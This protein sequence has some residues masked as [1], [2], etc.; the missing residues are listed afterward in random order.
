MDDEFGYE[1][2][3]RFRDDASRSRRAASAARC[4]DP[5]GTRASAASGAYT[6]VQQQ[7]NSP[8]VA[9]SRNNIRR[10]PGGRVGV[11]G[12]SA[13][14]DAAARADVADATAARAVASAKSAR[15]GDGGDREAGEGDPRGTVLMAFGKYANSTM[16][17]V[18]RASWRVSSLANGCVAPGGSAV[19]RRGNA[20]TRDPIIHRTQCQWG[21]DGGTGA[22]ILPSL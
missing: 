10:G 15:G 14:F 8:G 18:M 17:E 5:I 6:T 13:W 20:S 21:G 19:V 9:T 4:R 7:A 22:A 2:A 16:R 3:Q 12:G 11:G 1:T